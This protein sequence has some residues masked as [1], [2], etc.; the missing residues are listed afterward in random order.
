MDTMRVDGVN[1][2]S[3]SVV[4][5]F[6]V[7]FSV[8]KIPSVNTKT[9]NHPNSCGVSSI[10]TRNPVLMTNQKTNP[11]RRVTKMVLVCLHKPNHLQP[12]LMAWKHHR[13][14]KAKFLIQCKHQ[15]KLNFEN[16]NQPKRYN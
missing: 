5:H 8:L 2:L 7:M 11:K 13:A 3:M 12:Y 16:H 14:L 9:K 1:R 6:M 10:L 4:V 15:L